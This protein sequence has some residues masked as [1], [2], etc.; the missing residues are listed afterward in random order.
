MLAPKA[1][2]NASS[3]IT[4]FFTLSQYRHPSFV[5]RSEEAPLSTGMATLAIRFKAGHAHHCSVEE[6]GSAGMIRK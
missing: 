3:L 4:C 6:L 1:K 2:N 5:N